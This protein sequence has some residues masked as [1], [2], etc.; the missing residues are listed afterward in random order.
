MTIKYLK[1]DFDLDYLLGRALLL[2]RIAGP[3]ALSEHG[4]TSVS[5]WK[6]IGQ[7]RARLGAEELETLARMFPSYQVWLLT[8]KR[9]IGCEQ[10][11]PQEDG[12]AV[13]IV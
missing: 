10:T 5:R 3:K 4:S 13:E 8:G 12:A 11:T 6:N 1:D 9:E 2:M 7:G